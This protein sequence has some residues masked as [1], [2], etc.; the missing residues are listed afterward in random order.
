MTSEL[1]TVALNPRSTAFEEKTRLAVE[2]LKRLARQLVILVHTDYN[3]GEQTL[4]FIEA[5]I[6]RVTTI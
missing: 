5:N 3:S 1:E 2:A 6:M 4:T